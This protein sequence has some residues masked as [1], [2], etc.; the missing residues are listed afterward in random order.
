MS[1]CSNNHILSNQATIIVTGFI[2]ID[3]RIRCN[4]MTNKR[5]RLSWNLYIS[6]IRSIPYNGHAFSIFL[7]SI[8]TYK[9]IQVIIKIW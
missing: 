9:P 1:L 4:Q 2:H 8:R 5:I 6:S 7:V 3:L